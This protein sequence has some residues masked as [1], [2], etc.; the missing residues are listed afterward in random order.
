MCICVFKWQQLY[1]ILFLITYQTSQGLSHTT[2]KISH[3]VFTE[4]I[5]VVLFSAHLD[6]TVLTVFD[7][8]Y[9][10]ILDKTSFD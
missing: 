7:S 3:V 4:I 5:K 1:L 8:S 2:E 6:S 10:I 9:I